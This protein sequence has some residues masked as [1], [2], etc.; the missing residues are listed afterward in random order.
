ML[1]EGFWNLFCLSFTGFNL[2]L[3]RK[4]YHGT[5]PLL[6]DGEHGCRTVSAQRHATQAM[7]RQQKGS[8][9]GKRVKHQISWSGAVMNESLT[10]SIRL[11]P[12]MVAIPQPAIWS[13]DLL[14]RGL[15]NQ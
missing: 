14:D 2:I 11:L 1:E 13:I 5:P 9:S 4:A 15:L 3:I 7:R 8:G 10:Q 6:G 12:A